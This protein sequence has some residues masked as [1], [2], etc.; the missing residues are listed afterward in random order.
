MLL[1]GKDY[2]FF[3]VFL[4]LNP[5]ECVTKVLKHYN[6]TI[7]W[8][9]Q[10]SYMNSWIKYKKKEDQSSKLIRMLHNW[11]PD[12]QRRILTAPAL[13]K[14]EPLFD[15][16]SECLFLWV[17]RISPGGW[18]GRGAYACHLYLWTEQIPTV[19][20][21]QWQEDLHLHPTLH[22]DVFVDCKSSIC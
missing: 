21:G 4:W 8:W 14:E 16:S 1:G 19:T 17:R 13:D 11:R 7:L 15:S 18:D 5:L 20:S 3:F 12:A 2:C 22:W 9:K 10:R 6:D